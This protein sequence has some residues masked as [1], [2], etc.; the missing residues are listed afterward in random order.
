MKTTRLLLSTALL[1]AALLVGGCAAINAQNPSGNLRP[2]NAHVVGEQSGV[3]L[4]GHDVVSYFTQGKHAMGSAQFASTYENVTFHF[5]SAANKALFDK[6]PTKYIP[7]YGGYCA[8]GVVYGIP[9]GGDAD[10]WRIDGGKLYIFGG[11]GS[12]DAFE[13]DTAGNQK[14]AQKYW[15]EEVKGSNSFIQRSKRIIFKVPHYKS[16]ED[17]AKMVAAAKK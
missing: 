10:T 9:W 4:K 12:Q 8:N 17:L 14:L 15:D 16:G 6:E 1:S 7:Q 11:K 3:I 5:A 2:V 13:L